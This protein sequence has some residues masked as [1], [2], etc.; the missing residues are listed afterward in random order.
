MS[1]ESKKTSHLSKLAWIL[2]VLG[3]VAAAVFVIWVSRQ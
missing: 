2:I 3:F 1:D